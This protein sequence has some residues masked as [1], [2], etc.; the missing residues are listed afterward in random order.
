M[1]LRF[2]GIGKN[3]APF[4]AKTIG[5]NK[6]RQVLARV[7]AHVISGRRPLL[8]RAAVDS[9]LCRQVARHFHANADFTNFR[10]RPCHG[11]VSFCALACSALPGERS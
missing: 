3:I 4:G 8:E 5:T 7:S 1:V 9:H 6:P 11:I 10:G 2:G